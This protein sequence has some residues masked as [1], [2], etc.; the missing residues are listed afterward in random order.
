MK[1][2]RFFSSLMLLIGITVLT[3]CEKWDILYDCETNEVPGALFPGSPEGKYLYNNEGRFTLLNRYILRTDPMDMSRTKVIDGQFGPAKPVIESSNAYSLEIDFAGV[4][5]S[6]KKGKL[7]FTSKAIPVTVRFHHFII[8]NSST[9][10]TEMEGKMTIS[11]TMDLDGDRYVLSQYQ[12]EN[13][14]IT[15]YLKLKNGQRLRFHFNTLEDPLFIVDY[16]L[17]R[18]EPD[19]I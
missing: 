7:N 1:T 13:S 18:P 14:D 19:K 15:L 8:G 16:E 11:G 3:S 12:K 4:D 2:F 17:D 6:L 10:T 5:Y 9:D